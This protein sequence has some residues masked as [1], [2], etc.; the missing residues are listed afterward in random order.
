MIVLLA[1]NRFPTD[2]VARAL[3]SEGVKTT[4]FQWEHSLRELTL[5]QDL[6]KAVLIAQTPGIVAIG[7]RT[8]EARLLVGAETHLLVCA[9]SLAERERLALNESGANTIVVP[10]TSSVEHV[11]ERI[12]A[13]LILQGNGHLSSFGSLHGATKVMR[14]LYSEIEMLAG[15]NDS[16]LILGETGTGKELIAREI[17]GCSKRPEPFLKLNCAEFS[18]ELLRSELF[19]HAKGAFTGAHQENAGLMAE[20]GKGT[21]FL[22][23]IGEMD[24]YAQAMLLQVLEDRKFRAV[25]SNKIQNFSARLVLATHRNLEQM[26][27]QGKFRRDLLARIRDFK[28]QA[29]PLRDRRADIP[30]LV[31]YFL[32]KF[33]QEYPDRAASIPPGA[34]DY[35]FHSE[36]P[37]NVRQLLKVVRKAA[38]YKDQDGNISAA[39][40]QNEINIIN[41]QKQHIALNSA[42][43]DPTSD[44]IHDATRRMQKSYLIAVL[45]ETKGNKEAAYKMSGLGRSRF[46]DLLRELEIK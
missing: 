44:T 41:Q 24:I 7:E 42:S 5:P 33:N 36:W 46:Y 35:L 2:Q 29:P 1:Q 27:E 19:G 14:H 8:R 12:T 13:E 45:K 37:E 9:P 31:H 4:H 15:L 40:L 23:E 6:E 11:S 30:I 16:I 22:D 17:H 18:P 26:V 34:L 25:G 39:V 21:L 28:L 3:L 32:D 43:F 10:R 38:A 20:A